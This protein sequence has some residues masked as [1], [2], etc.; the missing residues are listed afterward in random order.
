MSLAPPRIFSA[1][2]NRTPKEPRGAQ[3]QSARRRSP[4][5][6]WPCVEGAPREAP[7][8]GGRPPKKKGFSAAG[9]FFPGGL[10]LLGGREAAAHRPPPRGGAARPPPQTSEARRRD[11]PRR[12][13]GGPPGEDQ[14]KSRAPELATAYQKGKARK[15]QP[16]NLNRRGAAMLYNF[17]SVALVL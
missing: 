4:R 3:A 6:A 17:R 11:A 12:E 2:P 14:A 9:G 13:A 10:P 16:H 7:K 8:A 15:G 1:G 5:R